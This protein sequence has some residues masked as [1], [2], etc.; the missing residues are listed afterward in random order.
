MSQDLLECVHFVKNQR[1]SLPHVDSSSGDRY[2]E[3]S[4]K[5]RIAIEAI[6]AA[7]GANLP[8]VKITERSDVARVSVAGIRASS[9]MGIDG[10]LANWVA[11][12]YRKLDA[13]R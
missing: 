3:T 11:A 12:A 6:V 13:Q 5:R 10:A 4:G 1:A 9:T 8:K 7:I 2:H